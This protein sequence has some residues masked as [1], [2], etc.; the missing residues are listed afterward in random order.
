MLGKVKE[1]IDRYRMLA[2]GD[3][4]LVGVSGGPDSV[5]LLHVLKEISPLF[6]LTLH[7]AHLNHGFRG[8]EAEADAVFVGSLA[9]EWGIE[10][11]K[12]EYDVPALIKKTGMSPQDAAHEA[13]FSFFRRVAARVGANKIALGHNLDD[14]AETVLI[15]LIRGGGME[16]L[17][18]MRPCRGDL[19]R[20]L[21][22]VTRQQI[23]Q[24]VQDHNL[25]TVTDSSNFKS[26]YVRN[27]VRLELV[28]LLQTFNPA[29]KRVLAQTA[30]LIRGEAD[31][32]D[33]LA[34]RAME[35]VRSAGSIAEGESLS[36]TGLAAEP[37]GLQRRIIR[38]AYAELAG[39]ARG[40]S[41]HHINDVL[42]LAEKETGSRL[43]LP[44]GVIV[45]KDYHTLELSAGEKVDPVPDFKYPLPVPGCILIPE[46]RV[47]VFAK[48]LPATELPEGEWY[49]EEAVPFRQAVLDFQR[50]SL[51]LF[52]RRRRHGDRF[53]PFKGRGEKKL[54]EI[55]IDRK[56]PRPQRDRIPLVASE[57]TIYWVPGITVADGC[58]VTGDTR[59]ILHLMVR[60]SLV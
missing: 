18:G 5:A 58:Q 4:V 14:Q 29:I 44:R 19:I 20:P 8:R 60:S 43:N 21:I 39:T 54:K 16:G 11:T 56:I 2:N 57:N 35:R 6:G 48:V 24:Y 59:Q 49:S 41:F 51:P 50:V 3:R 47:E 33:E 25:K 31:C 23:E 34:D 28:P 15:H 45:R 42:A 9:R 36:L 1:T 37:L 38:R 12:G 52:V 46:L 17:G 27:R 53:R 13:R 32:L 7:V 40:L 55:M 30:D 22:T 26:I 10:Y